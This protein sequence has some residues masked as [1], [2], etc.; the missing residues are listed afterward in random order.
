MEPAVEQKSPTILLSYKSY[1]MQQCLAQ[2]DMPMGITVQ[3]K[4]WWQTTIL[5]FDL[6]PSLT[7]KKKKKYKTGT[8]N[9][10]T[11][12]GTCMPQGWTCYGNFAKWT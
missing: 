4:L 3:Q 11:T 2:Q 8:V 9:L 1:E 10:I 5:W 12:Y 6:N 7:K